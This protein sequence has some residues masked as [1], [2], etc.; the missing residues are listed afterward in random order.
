MSTELLQI[1]LWLGLAAIATLIA[2]RIGLAIAALEMILGMLVGEFLPMPPTGAML[3]MVGAMLIAFLSGSETNILMFKKNWKNCLGIGFVAFFLPFFPV[4][5]YLRKYVGMEWPQASIISLALAETSIAVTYVIVVEGGLKGTKLGETILG[6]VF[7]TNMI[8]ISLLGGIFL[9]ESEW[10]YPLLLV[11]FLSLGIVPKLAQAFSRFSTLPIQAPATTKFLAATLAGLGGFAALAKTAA[12][13][14]AYVLGAMLSPF[15]PGLG[16]TANRLRILA[17]SL[18]TSFYFLRA[19]SLA[20]PEALFLNL[21]SALILFA[22]KFFPKFAGVYLLASYTG[23]SKADALK[24]ALSMSTGLTF[25]S[26]A[27]IYGL[28]EGILANND[29]T[30]LICAILLSATI[31]LLM[32]RFLRID[33]NKSN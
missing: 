25:G 23:W 9:S 14:P 3:A 4:L 8:M 21:N 24:L 11:I 16:D 6:A 2:P 31:P 28:S 32:L 13:F 20:N 27:A 33:A 1:S 15:I 26:F 18:F 22:L 30:A 7:V 17:F 29:Y 5:L 12:V 19:G 10:F